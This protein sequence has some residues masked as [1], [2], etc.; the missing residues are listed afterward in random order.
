MRSGSLVR[1]RQLARTLRELRLHAGL[2]IEAAAPRLDVSA[3]K[4]SRIENAHQ[5]VDVHIVRSML[6]LFD[7]GGDRWEKILELTREAS[8]KGWWRAYGLDDRGY[9]PLEAEASTVREFASSFVP[10]LLQTADYARV[11]FETS[12]RPR[13]PQILERDVKVRM[14]RQERLK[15][16][17]YPLELLTV[18]E[19]SVLHRVLGG[20]AAMRAQLDHLLDAAKL[21]TVSLQ[22]LPTDVGGHPGLDGA[23]TVLSFE[24]LGEPDM[25]YAEHPMGSIHIEKAED[26]MRAR[27]VFDHLS[28]VAL[29]PVEST[30]LIE[31][32]IAQM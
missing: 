29:S 9:V 10:G 12:L 8:A 23:F 20:H 26:V 28:S 6:D 17:E 24:G 21:D 2:T 15:S 3:S 11:L 19:E 27:V 18:I 32:V 7:I 1:R 16:A 31:Q 4:L 22:I 13:S 14:I 25:G 5:G 30:A